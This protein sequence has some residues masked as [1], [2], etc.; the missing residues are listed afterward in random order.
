MQRNKDE[1]K[2]IYTRGRNRGRSEKREEA[3]V[4]EKE[5]E[6]DVE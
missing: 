5:R 6:N 4:E 1:K 2:Y 3:C